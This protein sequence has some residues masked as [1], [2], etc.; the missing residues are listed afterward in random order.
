MIANRVHQVGLSHS[1]TTVDEQRI[2][3]SRRHC[4]HSLGRGMSELIAGTDD[5]LSKLKLS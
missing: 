5:E 4:R 2:V 3:R 1:H